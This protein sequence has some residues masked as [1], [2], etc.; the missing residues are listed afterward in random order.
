[1]FSEAE[2]TGEVM[3]FKADGGVDF[4][5]LASKCEGEGFAFGKKKGSYLGFSAVRCPAQHYFLC[6]QQ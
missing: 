5:A 3:M 6:M 1:M 2:K 4:A